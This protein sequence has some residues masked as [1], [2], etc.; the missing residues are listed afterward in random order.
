MQDPIRP[1]SLYVLDEELHQLEE[2]LLASGGEITEEMEVRWSELLAMRAGK[3][4]GY[5]KMIRKFEASAEAVRSERQRLQEA[6]RT[7]AKAAQT[8][9]DRLRDSMQA[10]GETEHLTSVGR[11]RLQRSGAR[12]VELKVDAE[13]LPDAFK[14]ITVNPD[15]QALGQALRDGDPEAE[16]YA[17][18]GEAGYYVRIY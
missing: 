3:M 12:P 1:L 14:R 13:A 16:R 6:E 15:L 4:E 17:Q 8:L 18:L 5:L 10:R 2:A 11:I 7:L 9:K